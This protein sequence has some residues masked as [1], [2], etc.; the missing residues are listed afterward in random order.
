[1]ESHYNGSDWGEPSRP[2]KIPKIF[3]SLAVFCDRIFLE[4]SQGKEGGMIIQASAK[5]IPL[6]DSSVH[7]VVTSPPY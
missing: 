7:C 1:M 5:L 3:L 2:R 6:A 4:F